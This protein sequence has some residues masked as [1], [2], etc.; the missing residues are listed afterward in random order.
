[1]ATLSPSP[2]LMEAV[3][4]VASRLCQCNPDQDILPGLIEQAKEVILTYLANGTLVAEGQPFSP[5]VAF[6]KTEPIPYHWWQDVEPPGTVIIERRA[7]I[8]GPYTRIYRVGTKYLDWDNSYIYYVPGSEFR[9]LPGDEAASTGFW[10]VRLRREDIV[11]LWP[12]APLSAVGHPPGLGDAIAAERTPS[13][14][15]PRRTRPPKVREAVFAWLDDLLRQ[16]SA[17]Y[18]DDRSNHQLAESWQAEP[19][20][21]GSIDYA[22][23]LISEWKRQNRLG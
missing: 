15:Q 22:R 4:E 19:K 12:E 13:T 20:H 18:V 9:N 3:R 14:S 1:M 11:R 5:D 10:S 16:H 8:A 21:V 7:G 17:A 2:S 6:P 23:K